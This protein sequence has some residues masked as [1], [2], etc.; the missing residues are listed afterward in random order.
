VNIIPSTTGSAISVVS[1][2]P[3]LE[4]KFDG[5]ALRVPSIVGSIV[6]IT[7]IARK[8][9]TVE[10]VNE[11]FR[12]AAADPQWNGVLKVVE[13][14]VVS[15]DL[16]G[17]PYA[18]VVD[19]GFTRVVDGNLVKVLAWYDNEWG[20]VSTLVSHVLEAGKSL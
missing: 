20:Y 8:D 6:D 16:V 9:T 18:S 10:E 7:F 17:E 11:I 5:I 4:G 3:E 13:D 12:T 19:S 15:S 2:I 1:A 14:Q